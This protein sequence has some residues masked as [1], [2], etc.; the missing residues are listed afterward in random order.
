MKT[1]KN[2]RN[3]KLKTKLISTCKLTIDNRED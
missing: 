2:K 3:N 1:N